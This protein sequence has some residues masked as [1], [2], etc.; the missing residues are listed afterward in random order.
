MNE[1]AESSEPAL[2][3]LWKQPLTGHS[4]THSLSVI[5]RATVLWTRNGSPEPLPEVQEWSSR[6]WERG[7]KQKGKDLVYLHVFVRA[8][9]CGLFEWKPPQRNPV[10]PVL[11][12]DEIG[13]IWDSDGDLPLMWHPHGMEGGKLCVYQDIVCVSGCV[14]VL[15]GA[16]CPLLSKQQ[17]CHP[18]PWWLVWALEILSNPRARLE[19]RRNAAKPFIFILAMRHAASWCQHRGAVH[20]SGA[21][22]RLAKTND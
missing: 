9:A 15:G 2:L 4:P 16:G 14:S 11:K 17:K 19:N 1:E 7:K 6:S 5:C 8:F 3:S 20:S 13:S 22:S 12:N 10:A 21:S 18:P